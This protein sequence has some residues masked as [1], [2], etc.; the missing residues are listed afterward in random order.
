MIQQNLV[1]SQKLKYAMKSKSSKA[2]NDIET[3][4]KARFKA[5]IEEYRGSHH[6]SLKLK[7]EIRSIAI[8]IQYSERDLFD[9]TK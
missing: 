8:K 3:A 7:D 2:K 4:W 5:T 9:M 1:E 6:Q